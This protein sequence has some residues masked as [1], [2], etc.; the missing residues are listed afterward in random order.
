VDG[1]V[2]LRCSPE[3]CMKRLEMRGRA[4]EDSVPQEYL[5]QINDRHEEWFIKKVDLPD[6]ISRKPSLVLD[7][8]G[9]LIN[10]LGLRQKTLKQVL[11]FAALISKP[12]VSGC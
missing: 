8:S 5:D 4:E 3:I 2:Y 7:C 12:N 9:D 1:F 10:D 6:N 11:D